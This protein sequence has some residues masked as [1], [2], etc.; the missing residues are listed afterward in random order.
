[1]NTLYIYNKDGSIHS[2]DA[3]IQDN[4]VTLPFGKEIEKVELKLEQFRVPVGTPGYFLLPNLNY[5]STPGTL[6]RF[7]ERPPVVEEHPAS[8]S[9]PVFGV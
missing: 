4:L 2:T 3:V 9:V 5:A 1:M 6:I 8:F 7:K